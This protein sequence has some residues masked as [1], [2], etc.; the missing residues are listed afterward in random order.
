MYF[1]CL[2]LFFGNSAMA[3]LIVARAMVFICQILSKQMSKIRVYI[4]CC[5][6]NG[7]FSAGKLVFLA[8]LFAIM[9]NGIM[10]KSFLG[11]A[12][13]AAATVAVNF[14]SFNTSIKVSAFE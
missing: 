10:K 3:P 14:E 6:A 2:R 7:D 12:T 4:I 1:I 5:T 11:D 9:W 13:A 8:T